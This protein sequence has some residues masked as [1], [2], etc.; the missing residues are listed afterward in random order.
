MSFVRHAESCGLL[1]E[2]PIADGRWHRCKTA[3]KPRKRNGC[4]LFDGSH[5]VVRNWATMNDYAAYREGGQVDRIS[6]RDFREMQR[7]QRARQESRWLDTRNIAEDMLKRARW[8]KH[9]YL[10]RKGFPADAGFVLDGDLLVPMR[11]VNDA[12]KLNSIQRIAEDGTKLFLSGGK[13]KGSVLKLGNDRARE[14]WMVEGYATG[15][16]VRD[17]LRDLRRSYQVIVAFSA[18]NLTHVAR[19]VQSPAF[20][21]ADNDESKAGEDAA[22][23]TGLPWVMPPDVG[24]DANDLHQEKGLRTLVRLMTGNLRAG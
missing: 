19:L 15:L 12:M 22:I 13:A 23:A 20:V 6:V 24:V 21:M 18:G 16:S 8:A 10:E 5:G 4:Y 3:D 14:R 9:P 17:A 11:D 7:R 1:I 2:D